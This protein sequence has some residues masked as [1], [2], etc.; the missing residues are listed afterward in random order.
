MRFRGQKERAYEGALTNSSRAL[1]LSN[2]LLA[3]QNA[4]SE[5]ESESELKTVKLHFA[6]GHQS[7]NQS[8]QK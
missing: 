3:F 1:Y 5:S 8:K 6:F 7:I 4:E 2:C